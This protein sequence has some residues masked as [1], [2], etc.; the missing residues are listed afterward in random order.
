MAFIRFFY[1]GPG[2]ILMVVGII[3]SIAWII[4]QGQDKQQAEAEKHQVQQQDRPLGH[5]QRFGSQKDQ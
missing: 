3:I 4:R 2:V 5:A 1:E